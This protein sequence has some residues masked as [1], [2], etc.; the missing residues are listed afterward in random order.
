MKVCRNSQPLLPSGPS[1]GFSHPKDHSMVEKVPWTHWGY[2][3]LFITFAKT[4]LE[5]TA[6][7]SCVSQS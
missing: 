3:S 5:T 7:L 2:P 1:E 4:L 6:A